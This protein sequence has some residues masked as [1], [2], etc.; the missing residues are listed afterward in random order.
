[1]IFEFTYTECTSPGPFKKE[2]GFKVK[3]VRLY[4]L[5]A[6]SSDSHQTLFN[7]F[8]TED[9]QGNLIRETL[10]EIV[11]HS[12]KIDAATT[13]LGGYSAPLVSP[14]SSPEEF[15]EIP[16]GF[17]YDLL[18]LPDGNSAWLFARLSTSGPANGRPG[19]PF[20]QGFLVPAATKSAIQGHA[21]LFSGVESP[22]PIDLFTW[23][24]WLNP[25]GDA[26]VDSSNLRSSSLL[27]PEISA[28]ELSV[29]HL[30]F[31]SENKST[32]F[33]VFRNVAGS[34]LVSKP[35]A[36]PGK[37]SQE[38][39]KWV[40]VVSH[41]IPPSVSW[42]CGFGSTWKTPAAAFQSALVSP[43]KERNSVESCIFPQ[44][45]WSIKPLEGLVGVNSWARIATKVFEYELDMVVYDS[46]NEIDKA[47]KWEPAYNH[48]SYALA[49]L[50]LA[51]LGL[52]AYDFG[53]E[54]IEIATACADLLEEL[55]WPSSSGD[56]LSVSA[57]VNMLKGP[58]SLYSTLVGRNKLDQ[59]LNDLSNPTKENT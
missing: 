36:L 31:M 10:D 11:L 37:D 32:A 22:R 27:F 17:I 39:S 38:F 25:R 56:P 45:F 16:K 28:E 43:N 6:G 55:T 18:Q 40:S 57:L 30:K 21:S 44:L 8:D 46:I 20:H 9:E 42:F 35:T 19:N 2:T 13:R 12:S 3:S 26:Q 58:E 14:F 59:K 33:E 34:F 47:F 23:T 50:A 52:T 5:A 49:P 29:A 7:A 4:K 15:A 54:G 48:M 51:A 41:L 1:M 53:E 24:G